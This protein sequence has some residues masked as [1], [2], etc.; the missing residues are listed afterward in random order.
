MSKNE[1]IYRNLSYDQENLSYDSDDSDAGLSELPD[2]DESVYNANDDFWCPP[3]ADGSADD[4]GDVSAYD[5]LVRDKPEL[6]PLKRE[7][8]MKEILRNEEKFVDVLNMLIVDYKI[9]LAN[10]LSDKELASLFPNIEKLL[11]L[12]TK[13]RDVLRQA[14]LGGK[15]K[16]RRICTAIESFRVRVNI[17]IYNKI[18]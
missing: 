5:T 9:P 1:V 12:H 3:K 14:C 8:A 13:L 18:I 2:I 11:E 16:T 15:G 7:H 10:F 4:S 6:G 17:C